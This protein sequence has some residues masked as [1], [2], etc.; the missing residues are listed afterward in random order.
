VPGRC[1]QVRGLRGRQ[2]WCDGRRTAEGSVALAACAGLSPAGTTTRA[3]YVAVR[4]PPRTAVPST[5]PSSYGVSEIAEAAPAWSAGTLE[6]ISMRR[7][8]GESSRAA[9]LC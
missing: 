5:A 7:P 4:M 6:M 1:Q 9:W 3:E 2:R 8:A